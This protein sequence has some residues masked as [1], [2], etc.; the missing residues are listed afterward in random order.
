[1]AEN[2]IPVE[3]A[4]SCRWIAIAAWAWVVTVMAAYLA[5]FGTLTQSIVSALGRVFGAV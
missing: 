5:G 3:D 1:M 2:K 4:R